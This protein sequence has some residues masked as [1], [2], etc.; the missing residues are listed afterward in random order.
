MH[1]HRLGRVRRL[2]PW[3]AAAGAGLSIVLA[4]VA[5]ALPACESTGPTT[6]QCERPGNTAITTSPP[7]NNNSPYFNEYPSGLG[8]GP[9]F[10]IP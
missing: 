8:F 1:P 7:Q 9:V 3:I 4:P 6:T 10:V 5:A 2:T